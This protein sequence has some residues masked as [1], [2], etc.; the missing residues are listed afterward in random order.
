MKLDL[1]NG[2]SD[3][4]L[5]RIRKHSAGSENLKSRTLKCHYCEHQTIIVFE[6]SQGHIQAKCKKCRKEAVYNVVLRRVMFRR[7]RG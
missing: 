6:N 1:K 4:V 2:L 7:I 3:A 5:A